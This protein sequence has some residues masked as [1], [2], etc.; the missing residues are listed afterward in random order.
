MVAM[1]LTATIT[2]DDIEKKNKKIDIHER[3]TPGA[4]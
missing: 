2:R 1:A 3:K 4:P